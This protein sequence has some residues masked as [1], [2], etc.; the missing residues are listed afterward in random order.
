MVGET[1]GGSDGLG[2]GKSVGARVGNLLAILLGKII[3]CS[4][5]VIVGEIDSNVLGNFVSG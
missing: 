5:A 4:V 2:K 1:V 3:S